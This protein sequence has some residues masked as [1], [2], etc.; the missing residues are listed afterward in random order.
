MSFNFDILKGFEFCESHS[1]KAAARE[2]D[3]RLLGD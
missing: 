2:A 1:G 3:R